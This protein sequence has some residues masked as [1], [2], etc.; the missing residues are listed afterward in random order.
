MMYIDELVDFRK[1]TNG[2]GTTGL[3][4]NSDTFCL[5]SLDVELD[6]T[7]FLTY[8][9]YLVHERLTNTQRV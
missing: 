7:I 5:G 6:F 3:G 9:A 1:N 2:T 4:F 8:S